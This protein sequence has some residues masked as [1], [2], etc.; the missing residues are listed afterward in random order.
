[1]PLN[2]RLTAQIPESTSTLKKKFI[3]NL[4]LIILLNLL[5]KPLWIFGIDRNVQIIV[6]HGD[7]GLYYALL[8]I[9]F[10]LNIILDLGITNYN[11][12]NISQNHQLLQKHFSTIVILKFILAVAYGLITFA[13][14]L[15][16]GYSGRELGLLIFLALNQLLISFT[17]YLRSNIAGMQMHTLNSLVSVLDRALMIVFCAVLIWGRIDGFEFNIEWFVYSQTA[18]YLIT[19]LIC[20]LIVAWKSNFPKLRYDRKFFL[21]VLRQSAPFALLALLMA[22]YTRMDAIMLEKILRPFGDVQAGIYY[23]GFRIFDAAY[24][25]AL[26]FAV[27]L[28]PMFSK[29]L[30]ERSCINDLTRLSSL[31]LFIPMIALAVGSQ[32]FRVEIMDLLY[33]DHV[34]E[35]ASFFGILM[36]AFLGMAGTIIFGTLLTANG[37]L[38]ELNITSAIAVGINLILN[39]ILIPKYYAFG[40][41]ISCLVTQFF[42]GFSQFLISARIF[43]FTWDPKLFTRVMIYLVAVILMGIGSTWVELSWWIA[44]LGFLGLSMVL[45][46]F[47]DLISLRAMLLM[48]R[49][50]GSQRGQEMG[51]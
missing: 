41:A 11:N 6:G 36:M 1:V 23:N 19:A 44:L 4:V 25:F 40:A 15:I 3:T 13:L 8:N 10:V 7:F 17:L 30:K 37:N 26:L 27:L 51:E 32:L 21:V 2:H 39:L 50:N 22:S 29:M 9:S 48:V 31:L 14:A 43:R 35:S 47:L 18:A 20:F 45:A 12:R 49:G 16:L 46:V 5:I 42:A 28:L 38:K 33:E 24:Q 34:A